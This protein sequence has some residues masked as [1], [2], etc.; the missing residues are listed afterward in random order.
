MEG[1][2]D[3]RPIWNILYWTALDA[4]GGN[5]VTTFD[6]SVAAYAPMSSATTA[7]TPQASDTPDIAAARPGRARAGQGRPTR[8]ARR[9]A[10]KAQARSQGTHAVSVAHLRPSARADARRRLPAD[11]NETNV[12]PTVCVETNNALNTLNRNNQFFVEQPRWAFK[13]DRATARKYILV[14][15]AS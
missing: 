14:R 11:A 10:G 8:E 7:V 1:A 12:M 5:L 15:I 2:H 4:G 13:C 6:R 9:P 3:A